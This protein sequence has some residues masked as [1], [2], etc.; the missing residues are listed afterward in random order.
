[1]C[2]AFQMRLIQ[3]KLSRFLRLRPSIEDLKARNIIPSTSVSQSLVSRWL[4]LQK[5]QLIQLLQRKIMGKSPTSLDM[6]SIRA[7]LSRLL[8]NRIHPIE[9]SAKK[10]T[11][12]KDIISWICPSVKGR[13][14]FFENF[15]FSSRVS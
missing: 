6:H 14:H 2:K 10:I 4:Q 15:S 11:Q 8:L 1:M 12:E 13:I 5:I 3:A 9:L 7:I